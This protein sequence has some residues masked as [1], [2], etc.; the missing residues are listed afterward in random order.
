MKRITQNAAFLILGMI[1]V[2]LFAFLSG[3]GTMVTYY[4]DGKVAGWE[5]NV[6]KNVN[7]ASATTTEKGIRVTK[8]TATIDD[9][10]VKAITDGVVAGV[11]RGIKP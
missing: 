1:L 10:A 3:C 8:G 11:V 6:L 2:C 7:F 9:D 4:P 5:V